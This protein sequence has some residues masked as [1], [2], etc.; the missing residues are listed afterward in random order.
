MIQMVG[1]SSIGLCATCS[2]MRQMTSDRG[3]FFYLC[4]RSLTEPSFPKYPALP[5]LQCVGYVR[6]EETEE[7]T[8]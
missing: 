7:S 4:G 2:F 8:P 1:Q 5:V 3:S 6:V